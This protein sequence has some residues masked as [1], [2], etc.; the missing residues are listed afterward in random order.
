VKALIVLALSAAACGRIGF[1]AAGDATPVSGMVGWWK[2]DDGSGTQARDAYGSTTGSLVGSGLVW[3]PTGG[4]FG[5]A[6]QFPGTN[7]TDVLFGTPPLFAN[8]PGVTV[9]AWINPSSV[10]LA[11]APHCFFDH[12][13]SAPPGGW[14]GVVAKF[15]DGD[16]G[17][18]A[19][20]ALNDAVIR[21]SMPG[22][23][24]VGTWSHVVAT[25]D[26]THL[27]SGIHIYVDG[28]EVTYSQSFDAM[29]TV[30]PDDST[31]P[32]AIG[33]VGPSGFAGIMDDVKLFDRV[34]SPAEVTQL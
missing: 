21:A 31:I 10:Q 3:L 34:L 5:G 9:S 22:T 6:L 19:D 14:Y 28:V 2:L 24:A 1:G 27:A 26:G 25:W 12:G 11:T 17:F 15:A 18:T 7:D 33:C 32:V 20:F 23:V 4:K 29:A 13:G 16:V 30:R 8:L